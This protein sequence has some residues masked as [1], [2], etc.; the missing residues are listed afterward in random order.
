MLSQAKAPWKEKAWR[1]EVSMLPGWQVA[2]GAAWTASPP[3]TA[4]A[5]WKSGRRERRVSYSWALFYGRKNGS[6]GSL[7][8]SYQFCYAMAIWVK[9]FPFTC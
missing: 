3:H 8:G 9:L 1:E 5:E 6:H 2:S 4:G 7:A